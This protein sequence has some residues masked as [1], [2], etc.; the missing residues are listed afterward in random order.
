MHQQ[1]HLQTASGSHST[2]TMPSLDAR[3]DG[4]TTTHTAPLR[5]MPFKTFRYEGQWQTTA[6]HLPAMTPCK[7]L[8]CKE[9]WQP[10]PHA[11]PFDN[12]RHHCGCKGEVVPIMQNIVQVCST[13]MS[14]S[15]FCFLLLLLSSPSGY[16]DTFCWGWCCTRCWLI[17]FWPAPLLVIF[18]KSFDYFC[19]FLF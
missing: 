13:L 8:G 14:T 5:M 10:A 4:R 3:G 2:K 16:R 18:S 19:L 1:C 6:Q 17:G 15:K 11:A 9:R 12:S 7:H